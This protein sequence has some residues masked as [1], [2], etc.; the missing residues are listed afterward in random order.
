FMKAELTAAVTSLGYTEGNKYF[1]DQYCL[2]ALKDLIRYLRR[3]DDT[4]GIRRE[5]G[6]M[7]L[8]Q[9]NLIPILCEYHSD[10]ALFDVALRLLVNLTNP[11]LLLF[12][13]EM[14]TDKVERN[15]YLQH[16]G[17]LQSYKPVLASDKFW[18]V[19]TDKLKLLLVKEPEDRMEDDKLLTERILI[20]IRNILDIPITP[21]DEK[22]TD[23]DASVHDQVLWS[24]HLSGM[25]DVIIYLASNE[26]E[27]HFCMHVMEIISLML[28]EQNPASLAQ[29]AAQR[30]VA[31][32]QKDTE[33][34][35]AMVQ[36]ESSEREA[37]YKKMTASRSSIFRGTFCVKDVK[38]I[39]DKDLIVHRTL[40]D[41]KPIDFHQN[42]TGKRKAKNRM[43]LPSCNVTRKST[44]SIRL[45]LKEFCLQMLNGAY[46]SLMHIV[47]DCLVRLKTQD[48]DETYYLWAVKFFMEF[49]RNCGKFRVEL[50]SETMSIGLFHYIQNQVQT[51]SE[52]IT[53]DKKK[54]ALW[55]RR[56]N[57]ALCAYQ[58]LLMT[59]NAMDKYGSE[60]IRNSSRVLKSNVFY[61]P[62]YREMCLVLLLNYKE[63]QHSLTYLKDLV[64]T[65]HIFLKLFEQF[66]KGNR[67][68]VVQNK[69]KVPQKRKKSKPKKK[70]SEEEETPPPIFDEIAVEISSALQEKP[71]L[72]DDVVPFDAASDLPMDDQRVIAMGKIVKLLKE[73]KSHLAVAL[74]R[75]CRE[76][77]PEGEVFGAPEVG[78]EDELLLLR[79]LYHTELPIDVAGE[80]PNAE[81]EEED[82]DNKETEEEEEEMSTVRRS[83]KELQFEEFIRRFAHK[84][85]VKSYCHLL[86]SY[87][88]NTTLTNHCVIKILHRIAFDCKMPAMIFQLSI[89][90]TF[91]KI[92]DDP[93]AKTETTELYKFAI[94]IMRKFAETAQVNPKIFVE[95]LFWKTAREAAE[96]EVGYG[97]VQDPCTRFGWSEEE[98]DELQRLHQ[99]FRDVQE[100]GDVVDRIMANLINQ[101]RSRRVIIKKMKEMG[102]I[103]DAK[104]LAKTKRSSKIRPSKEW[105]EH[106]VEEL[107]RIFPEVRESSDPLGM[108]IDRLPVRRAKNRVREKILELGLVEDVK[109]LRKKRPGKSAGSK[110]SNRDESDSED[111]RAEPREGPAG[112]GD[113]ESDE[114]EESDEGESD[115]E[116][117][118]KTKELKTQHRPKQYGRKEGL[119]WLVE[120]LSETLED[121]EDGEGDEEAIP[122]V[123]LTDIS[124]DAMEDHTFLKF[125]AKLGLAPPA[126][127]QEQFWRIPSTL[128]SADLR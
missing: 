93:R 53:V 21:E 23:D 55:S 4:I 30:S 57:V 123:P 86:R 3:D 68:L 15:Y 7:K 60:S 41:G 49:N 99:E 78:P 59:L 22:R 42:K 106:E 95:L 97:N 40:T 126:S 127:E 124:N 89:F 72:T 121:R 9:T 17:H 14:P 61:V 44:L 112:L 80:E 103:M 76:V 105:T 69:S 27:R 102:L 24:M 85:V 101:T 125:I 48:H 83:E 65:N 119:A 52:S 10:E 84:N 39:T 19:L 79:E 37:R 74:L 108:L 50:V 77:W 2:E 111:G 118:S 25:E 43:P 66:A 71:S 75:A 120:C 116:P 56:L 64:E 8:V 58:E 6:Q 46:N 13:E 90:K 32:K 16:V 45:M 81:S 29:T 110:E 63:N 62:E 107:R 34:L 31:E 38:S 128:T 94:Y 87:S 12:N 91:Q 1:K 73:S 115:N 88:T 33:E 20:L 28:R 11:T 113:S 47:K 70:K 114:S 122:I 98:E 82:A 104:S 26:N 54:A 67:H 96:I 92:M 100:G 18:V 109:E 35:V 5:L 36:K 51:Y 117:V